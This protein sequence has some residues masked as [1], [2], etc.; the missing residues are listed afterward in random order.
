MQSVCPK[1]KKQHNLRRSEGIK[2]RRDPRI[3]SLNTPASVV[4]IYLFS[5][6]IVYIFSYIISILNFILIFIFIAW[7]FIQDPR[8]LNIGRG[9][10]FLIN[11]IIKQ[12]YIFWN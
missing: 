4:F 7:G 9:I 8:P 12:F 2:R 3:I 1:E 6:L 10:S 5:F 11:A